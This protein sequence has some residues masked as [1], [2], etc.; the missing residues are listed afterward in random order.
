MD[1]QRIA[2]L[3]EEL[4]DATERCTTIALLSQRYPE[5]GLAEAYEI[6]RQVME[7][8]LAGGERLA[9]WKVGYTNQPA[10]QAAGTDQ[11]MYGPIYA[12]SVYRDGRFPCSPYV[13]P[14]A[15]PEICFL[16]R[17][18]LHGPDVTE[19]DVLAATE[20]VLPALEMVQRHY[21]GP[22]SRAVDA[23]ADGGAQA[24]LVLPSGGVSPAG[25]DLAA[26]SM[27]LEKNGALIGA[28][29]GAIVL[30][31]PARPVAWL[32][33]QLAARGFG[34]KAGDLIS[35]GT[36]AGAHEIAS[37][38]HLRLHYPE[39]GTLEVTVIA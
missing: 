34:L 20:V 31:H 15:E 1:P 6:Q 3:A 4:A 13:A 8:R 33:H 21:H 25:Q 37:G 24:G 30:G 16:L 23:V 26:V 19:Q 10:Q 22:P 32:V 27:T 12:S 39:L 28:A 9:G 14:R 5:L 36:L 29:T 35:S 17:A 18:D 38:D 11:P 7:R 2:R